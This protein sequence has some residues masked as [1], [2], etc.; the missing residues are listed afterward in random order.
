MS[1]DRK[2]LNQLEGRSPSGSPDKDSYIEQACYA[3]RDK[4]LNE[5]KVEDLRMLISQGMG[6][7][8]LMPMAFR[9]LSKNPLAEGMHYPG[10]LLASVLRAP[11]EFFRENPLSR[12]TAEAAY[13]D[14]ERHL[15]R[16]DEIDRR[17]VGKALQEA[18]AT[19]ARGNSSSPRST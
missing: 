13:R 18:W 10:D 5:M 1:F 14:A 6:L 15:R 11:P 12:A 3:L 7:K 2:T 16:L 4:P 17:H 9:E 8:F 19:F